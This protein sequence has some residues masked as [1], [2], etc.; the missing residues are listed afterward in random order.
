MLSSDSQSQSQ[1]V[2]YL[3]CSSTLKMEATRSS[4]TWVE[5]HGAARRYIAEDRTFNNCIIYL[6]IS[7]V[8][9]NSME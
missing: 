9:F 4:E 5:F 6:S 7:H 1:L 3:A 8:L 2:A